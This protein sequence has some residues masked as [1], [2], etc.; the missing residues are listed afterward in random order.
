MEDLK[1]QNLQFNVNDKFN[2]EQYLIVIND[3]ETG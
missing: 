2:S 1:R 3:F